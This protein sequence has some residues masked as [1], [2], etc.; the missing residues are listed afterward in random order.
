MGT[1]LHWIVP[2]RLDQRTGGY[3]YDR[4]IVDG[5]VALGREV[6]VHELPGRF[7]DADEEA[8]AAAGAVIDGLGEGDVVIDG[9]A[10]LAF[11]AHV[12]RLPEGWIGLIHHPLSMETGLT[13]AD[14]ARL[15]AIE[16]RLMR[17]AARLVVTSP[18]TARDLQAFDLDPAEI[19]VVTPGVEP[20]P[21]AG[22]TPEDRPSAL[23]TVGSLTPRKGHLTLLE[24]LCRL[25]DLD[26]H[27]D[28][29][30]SPAW[31]PEHAA[32]IERKIDVLGLEEWVDLAGEQDDAGLA[33]FY[34]RADLFVLASHHEGYGMVLT[35]AL[36]RGLPIVSTTAGAIPETVPAGAG[37]LVP[38][39]DA[40]AL[41]SALRVLLTDRKSYRELAAGAADARLMLSS[42]E[43]AA[44]QFADIVE[45]GAGRHRGGER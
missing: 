35:E 43:D 25:T 30:G 41:A 18:G 7:P 27:L 45:Q 8:I 14:V 4:R 21:L 42:W 37:R 36:A 26:W 32:E 10:L 17:R 28:L 24:A 38:P 6:Q 20:A 5:L 11:E 19:A 39:G 16:G 15:A 9:L 1:P 2:G 33:G 34:D 22:I 40:T 23:L 12:E 31:D 29:V 3:I 13:A 44:R